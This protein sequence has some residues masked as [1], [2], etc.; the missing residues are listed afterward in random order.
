M[1]RKHLLTRPIYVC[2]V[3]EAHVS[4]LFTTS[5]QDNV[6]VAYIITSFIDLHPA[7]EG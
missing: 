2:N 3:V 5:I 1:L 4:T 6:A 7:Q